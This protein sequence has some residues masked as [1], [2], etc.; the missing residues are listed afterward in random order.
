MTPVDFY[1]DCYFSIQEC[2]NKWLEAWVDSRF[3]IDLKTV[4]QETQ[5][6]LAQVYVAKYNSYF[7]NMK[8]GDIKRYDSIENL[9]ESIYHDFDYWTR[10][11]EGRAFYEEWDEKLHSSIRIKECVRPIEVESKEVEINRVCNRLK[12]IAHLLFAGEEYTE[13]E[14][15]KMVDDAAAQAGYESMVKYGA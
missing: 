4:T 6:E 11:L 12:E 13:E 15:D 7:D 3:N 8:L 9:A 14:L 2:A 1:N 5:I 10:S